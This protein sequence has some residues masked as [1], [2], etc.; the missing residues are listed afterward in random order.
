M[1]QIPPRPDETAIAPPEFRDALADL[2]QMGLRVARM[3]GRIAEAETALA[4]AAS[5][6]RVAEG[7]SAM[8]ASLT[9][10]MKADRAAAAAKARHD[11][12]ARTEVV[13]AAFAQVSHSIQLTVLLAERLDRGQARPSGVDNRH[14]KAMRQIARG[15]AEAT[16][17]GGSP[18][19]V[20][21]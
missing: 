1:N 15:V 12:V 18:K 2:V 17:R 21:R 10:A 13:A 8:T 4:V 3:V 14:A 20:R 7:A 19:Q 11:L 16:G 9:E 5:Q 6:A